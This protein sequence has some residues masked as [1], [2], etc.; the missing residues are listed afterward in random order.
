MSVI[1]WSPI[2]SILNNR[3]AG[4]V[5]IGRPGSGKTFFLLNVAVN[6]LMTSCRVIYLDPK[7]DASVLREVYPD[8]KLTDVNNI[9]PGAMNP[10]KILKEINSNVI[11]AIISCICGKLDDNKMIAIAPIVNDFIIMNSRNIGGTNFSALANYLYSSENIEAQAVGTMLKLNEDSKYGK[12]L[13]GEG[14]SSFNLGKKSEIISL[15]GLPLPNINS[16]QDMNQE[17]RFSSAIIYILCKMLKEVLIEDSKL[18]TVFIVDEAYLMF[19]NPAITA[20][21]NEFLVLGRSLNVATVLASQNI[22]HFPKGIGQLISSKFMFAS[23]RREALEFLEEFDISSSSESFDRESIL[24]YISNIE[25]KIKG[26]GGCFFIDSKNR[27]GFIRIKSNLGVTSNPL[28][29]KR[30]EKE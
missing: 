16:V 21:I 26:P 9:E 7:N 3:P 8:I 4:T 12:I 15:F 11:L 1:R 5:V 17:E 20:I 24:D 14:G 27:G 23:S 2:N 6:A 18:P 28:L 19:A 13:F 25:E 22:T 30:K 29:K 10:F